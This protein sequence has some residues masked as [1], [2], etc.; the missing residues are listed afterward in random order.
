VT[1]PTST[2]IHEPGSAGPTDRSPVRP[3]VLGIGAA[4]SAGAALVHA[5]A[6]GSHAG[7][8]T[9]QALFSACAALQL[10]WAASAVLAP[11]RAVAAAGVAINAA[12]VLA[13]LASR[14]VGWPVVD[15]LAEPEAIGAQDL[16]GAVL[17]VLAAGAAAVSLVP[18]WGRRAL[19]AG[20]LAA[21][22]IAV[23]LLAVP[24]MAADHATGTGHDHDEPTETA[25][26][27]DHDHGGGDVAAHDDHDAGS[28]GGDSAGGGDA[29]GL[30]AREH[31]HAIPER[32][33]HEPTDDQLE[34]A[35]ELIDETTEATAGY[36]DVAAAEAAGYRTIGDSASGV[37]HFIHPEYNSD[38]VALD[39]ERPESLVYEVGPNGERTLIS[40]MYILP[41]GSTMDDVPDIAG[42][43][44]IWHGH[45]NLCFDQATGRISG[46]VVRDRCV[47]RGEKWNTPPMLHVWVTPNECGP[48]AGTDARRM[49]GSCVEGP[50]L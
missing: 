10:G 15:A 17:G 39:R 4:A 3:G 35:R 34:A 47:P 32:L 7:H 16:L 31:A 22:G 21:G 9:L 49:T 28:D 26:A 41:P 13:W 11:R 14:T 29:G 23:L 30:L 46:F 43:L 42:N 37:E 40:V 2:A 18:R 20:W 38:D 25:A 19:G 12:A 45:D 36:A 44:T 1:D 33:D 48:F 27:E 50:E 6:A 5:A 8:G 24:A